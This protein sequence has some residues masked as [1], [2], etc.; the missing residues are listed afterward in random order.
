MTTDQ[1]NRNTLDAMLAATF[2]QHD[3]PRGAPLRDYPGCTEQIVDD[4]LAHE[5]SMRRYND[6]ERWPV[7]IETVQRYLV[8]VEAD[9]PR[10]AKQKVRDDSEWYERITH[11]SPFDGGL[12]SA[13]SPEEWEAREE[14]YEDHGPLNRCH[15]CEKNPPWGGSIAYLV[16]FREC[17]V[18]L[19]EIA[20]RDAYY[21]QVRAARTGQ[22]G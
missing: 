10:A 7:V 4:L 13:D 8:W 2:E 6:T 20:A 9:N 11:E 17:P 3:V 18:G 21:A 12:Y 1:P 19:A 14:I 15:V 22:E 16:H 5:R